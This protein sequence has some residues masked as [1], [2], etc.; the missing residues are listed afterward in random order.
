MAI[1]P[2]FAANYTDP[3]FDRVMNYGCG[4]LLILT[5]ILALFFNAVVFYVNVTQDR[6]GPT[7]ALFLILAS[8][9][10]LYTVVRVP[11]TTYNL[12]NPNVQPRV[13]NAKPTTIQYVVTIGGYAV[14]TSVW[15]LFSISILRFIKLGCPVWATAHSKATVLIA[16]VPMV[17]QLLYVMF[18]A[19][20]PMKSETM[21]SNTAQ[22]V[23]ADSKNSFLD[24]GY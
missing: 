13:K 18:T 6:I 19:L 9:D 7:R 1:F 8:S 16:V 15:V 14:Y 20:E 5:S 4:A 22:G 3:T 11:Y 17:V 10:F 21:W 23:F 24:F 12:I 2:P